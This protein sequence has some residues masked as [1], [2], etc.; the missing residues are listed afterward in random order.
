[1][2]NNKLVTY[3]GF[4]VKSNSIIFG[5][6]NIVETRKKQLLVVICSTINEKNESK[7]LNFC[8][9]KNLALIKLKNLTL[10]EL[11][12]RDNVKAVSINNF[13]LAKAIISLSENF[14]IKKRGMF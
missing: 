13:N 10:S 5:L 12:K 3:F 7:L 8:E 1:M 11:V 14:E 6:D 2:Q 9:K 4:S